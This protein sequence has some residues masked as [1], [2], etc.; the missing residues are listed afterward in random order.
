VSVLNAAF[1]DR[2]S[3]PDGDARCA[4]RIVESREQAGA[5][6]SNS[7]LAVLTQ[8][9]VGHVQH[10]PVSCPPEKAVDSGSLAG[11]PLCQAKLPKY[12]KPGGLNH[13]PRTDWFRFFE[14][15]EQRDLLSLPVKKERGCEAAR[16]AS[17]NRN[18]QSPHPN[19]IALG[20]PLASRTCQP[21]ARASSTA[22]FNIA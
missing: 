8:I 9:P 16:A 15:L 21:F 17:R 6:D 18:A 20:A 2:S 4:N 11:D 19:G 1:G 3:A 13:Q 7:E 14:P 12:G 22:D 5:M 10:H